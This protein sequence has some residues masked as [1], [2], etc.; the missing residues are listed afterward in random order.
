MGA[1]SLFM[2]FFLVFPYIGFWNILGVGTQPIFFLC[3]LSFLAFKKPQIFGTVIILSILIAIAEQLFSIAVHG[4]FVLVRIDLILII[5]TSLA[6]GN[7]ADGL[8]NCLALRSRVK[9]ALAVA[10]VLFVLMLLVYIFLPTLASWL[11]L[12]SSGHPQFFGGLGVSYYAPEPGLSAFGILSAYVLFVIFWNKSSKVLEIGVLLLVVALL[13]STLS[14]TGC[15]LI[16]A[17]TYLYI[18]RN[19]IRL[20]L[21]VWPLLFLFVLFLL[22]FRADPYLFDHPI[23]RFQALIYLSEY[24][25]SSPSIRVNNLISLF[26][27]FLAMY[28]NRIEYGVHPVGVVS[29]M[30]L[31]PFATVVFLFFHLYSLSYPIGLIF[32]LSCIMLPLSNPFFFSIFLIDRLRKS[33][34]HCRSYG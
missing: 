32:L 3:F 14:L 17:V 34:L 15:V 30:T 23:Q 31:I 24:Q 29:Y 2:P 26:D 18:M 21:F 1:I 5:V 19:G 10:F 4:I 33:R 11:N 12:F 25:D 16:F 13:L 8:V 20:S 28:S 22:I 9:F 7:V 27:D 6:Y